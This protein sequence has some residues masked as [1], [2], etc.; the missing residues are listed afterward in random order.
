MCHLQKTIELEE[1]PEL[2]IKEVLSDFL[3]DE[4]TAQSKGVDVEGILG[5]F[6]LTK[7][8]LMALKK[9]E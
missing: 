7:K 3:T 1:S 9:G 5:Y 2:A 8:E 4:S 6:G